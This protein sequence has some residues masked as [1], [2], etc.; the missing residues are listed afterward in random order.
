MHDRRRSLRLGLTGR[1]RVLPLIAGERHLA[2]V[3]VRDDDRVAGLGD[4]HDRATTLDTTQRDSLLSVHFF[5][6]CHCLSLL[7]MCRVRAGRDAL[8]ELIIE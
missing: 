1:D 4:L 7:G 5:G 6:A 2:A 8:H 3:V